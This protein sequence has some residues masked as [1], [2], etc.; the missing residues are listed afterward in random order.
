MP[1]DPRIR[2]R[3]VADAN[4]L[5]ACAALSADK[6]SDGVVEHVRRCFGEQELI[7]VRIHAGDR[8]E[9]EAS[10]S[11]LAERIPCEVVQ[12]VG[13]TVTLYRPRSDGDAGGDQN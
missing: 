11:R 6:I 7:K 4:K 9:C 8:A 5:K 10:A 1:I 3:L 2:R 12:R 13:R